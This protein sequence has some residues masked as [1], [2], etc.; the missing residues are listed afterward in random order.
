MIKNWIFCKRHSFFNVVVIIV[1]TTFINHGLYEDAF[2]IV[3]F[4]ATIGC[5]IYMYKCDKNEN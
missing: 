2:Y 3:L 5:L 1:M 4:G